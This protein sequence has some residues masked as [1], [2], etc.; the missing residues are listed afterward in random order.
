MDGIWTNS[1]QYEATAPCRQRKQGRV[2]LILY[3]SI[4]WSRMA[5][6]SARRFKRVP[7][8][9]NTPGAITGFL[10]IIRRYPKAYILYLVTSLN[11]PVGTNSTL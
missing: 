6:Q 10:L 2:L 7:T 4:S 5:K 1:Y 3:P 8:A 11:M 9:N